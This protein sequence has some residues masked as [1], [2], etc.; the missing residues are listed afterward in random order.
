MAQINISF[1]QQ[2][3][4]RM[5]G[6]DTGTAYRELLRGAL[7]AVLQAESEAQLGAGRYERTEGRSDVRNGTRTRTLVTRIGPIDLTVPRHRNVP[8][9]TLVF[10]NFSRSE[11]ALVTT[12]AEMVVGGVSTAKV[13]RVMRELCGRSFSKSAVSEAC[14][15]LDAEVRRFRERPLEQEYPFV[16]VDATFPKAREDHRVRSKALMIAVGL[17]REGTKEVIGF[18]VYDCEDA[19]SWGDFAAGLKARGLHGVRL[20]T[21]D[22]RPEIPAAF[23]R[24]FPDVPWQRCQAHLTRNVAEAAPKGLRAGLRLELAEMFNCRTVGQAGRRRD[25]IVAD[26]RDQAPKAMERLDDGFDDA[27]TVMELPE[28][29]RKP[30]R[31]TNIVERLNGEVARRAKAVRVFPNAGS[32]E[33]LVGALLC[34]ENDRWQAR[35]KLY[36][37]P[38]L[39][40]M[41]RAVERLRKV[42]VRQRKAREAA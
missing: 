9:K 34:E 35:S 40:E 14:R 16:L 32:V 18:G 39:L 6:D 33:R 10:E 24:H 38:A 30:V 26:Y 22:A 28:A 31:T 12:M 15:E 20:L 8:F 11:A 41:D 1:N 42:A 37:K 13:G 5:L 17:T 23:S 21:S 29:L 27:M 25:E 3:I 36:Y 7:N 19:A 2:E 4:L